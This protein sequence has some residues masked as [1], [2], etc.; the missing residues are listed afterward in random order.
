MFLKRVVWLFT[1]NPAQLNYIRTLNFQ[2]KEKLD[3]NRSDGNSYNIYSELGVLNISQYHPYKNS[4]QIT[5]TC[6]IFN[7]NV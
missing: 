1:M 3:F 2:M 7:L 6:K 4:S 5:M